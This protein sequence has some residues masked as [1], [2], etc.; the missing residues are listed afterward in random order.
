L[1]AEQPE[2]PHDKVACTIEGSAEPASDQ[3]PVGLGISFPALVPELKTEEAFHESNTE[4][5]I[6]RAV[7]ASTLPALAYG[8]VHPRVSSDSPN[9]ERAHRYRSPCPS[10]DSPRPHDR[11]EILR[12]QA[13]VALAPHASRNRSLSPR[14]SLALSSRR[15]CMAILNSPLTTTSVVTPTIEI[16]PAVRIKRSKSPPP[17]LK[18]TRLQSP[19]EKLFT[20]WKI[21]DSRASYDEPMVVETP[22]ISKAM[23]LGKTDKI[24]NGNAVNVQQGKNP[25]NDEDV[26][27]EVPFGF[28]DEMYCDIESGKKMSISQ[29]TP[30]RL[31]A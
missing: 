23:S 18:P 7:E 17:T 5:S 26:T 12:L 8:K 13:K 19:V 21:A 24:E 11:P 10:P 4:T 1:A 2:I 22:V 6:V 28:T 25:F 30:L 16:T 14:P 20:S 9:D 31:K 29:P 15:N 3:K 27:T